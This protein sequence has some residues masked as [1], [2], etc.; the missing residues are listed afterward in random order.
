MQVLQATFPVR[1]SVKKIL[2][3]SL[4]QDSIKSC[5][6]DNLK[7]CISLTFSSCD[8]GF[9]DKWKR[10]DLFSEAIEEKKRGGLMT[11]PYS[12]QKQKAVKLPISII[13]QRNY[14]PRGTAT[15]ITAAVSVDLRSESAFP[16]TREKIIP[17]RD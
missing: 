1:M 11:I 12:S 8:N 9:Q 6:S 7:C 15:P 5:S 2:Q 10:V 13:S 3:H 16:S 17:C 14:S 4:L